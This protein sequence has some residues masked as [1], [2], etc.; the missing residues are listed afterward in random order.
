MTILNSTNNQDFPFE[1]VNLDFF[2]DSKGSSYEIYLN[3]NNNLLE[4]LLQMF[5]SLF[6]SVDN[7]IKIYN[8][9]WWDFCLDTWD[10][11]NDDYNYELTGKSNESKAYLKML[12]SSFIEKDYSGICTCNDWNKFLPLVLT[13][14]LTHQAPYS[15]LFFNTEEDFFFYFHHTGS[16]G[17]Y[18]N[19][20]RTSVKKIMSIAEREYRIVAYP[21]PC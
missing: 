5:R 17:F 15:P 2:P 18:N 4:D 12:Q 16:I 9:S 11:E 21:P 8:Y 20:E 19:S 1:W 14:I 7:N 13:C 6:Q 3:K 10:I